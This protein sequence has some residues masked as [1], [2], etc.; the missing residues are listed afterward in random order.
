MLES[1][2]V[3]G[4]TRGDEG[5]LA[6]R[7]ICFV[8]IDIWEWIDGLRWKYVGMNMEDWWDRQVG[9][10]ESVYI[11]RDERQ[12]CSTFHSCPLD[13]RPGRK[14]VLW[15]GDKRHHTV[16]IGSLNWYLP[17]KPHLTVGRRPYPWSRQPTSPPVSTA[18]TLPPYLLTHSQK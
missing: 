4:V 8:S 12:D 14:V 18:G 3:L 9:W 16:G 7:F 6:D 11:S 2:S 10:N 15:S 13:Y 1:A 5:G 17:E